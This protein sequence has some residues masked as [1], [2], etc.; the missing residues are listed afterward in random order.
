MVTIQHYYS[1]LIAKAFKMT[2]LYPVNRNVFKSED[3]APSKASSTVAHV[4]GSF[5]DEVPE[6][7]PMEPPANA[8]ESD[9][10]D[11]ASMKNMIQPYPRL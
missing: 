1:A 6:S 2:G 5:P 7:D 4:P 3:F 11:E 10:E 9:P 8:E